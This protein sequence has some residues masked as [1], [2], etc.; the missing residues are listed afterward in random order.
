[1][2]FCSLSM[3]QHFIFITCPDYVRK[4]DK[5]N[6][7]NV[8]SVLDLNSFG[9]SSV[10]NENVQNINDWSDDHFIY[11]LSFLQLTASAIRLLEPYKMELFIDCVS[12]I[13]GHDTTNLKFNSTEIK[14][15]WTLIVHSALRILLE[16][17]RSSSQLLNKIHNDE[18]FFQKIIDML[19]HTSN[20]DQ[21]ENIRLQALELISIIVSEEQ[22]SQM[23]E[24]DKVCFIFTQSNNRF[25]C[26]FSW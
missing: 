18:K 12:H 8:F 17:G 5:P 14:I 2:D 11:S 24:M 25:S 16:I 13:L 9:Y 7:K 21:D 4:C 1:M 6:G 26:S 22:F 20:N 19:E 15:L 10:L 3:T 23:F